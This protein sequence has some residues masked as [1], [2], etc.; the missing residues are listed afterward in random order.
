MY[1]ARHLSKGLRGNDYIK[2]VIT[3]VCKADND[4]VRILP[5]RHGHKRADHRR[6]VISIVGSIALLGSSVCF[7]L[8]TA[9]KK[10]VL[11]RLQ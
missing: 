2:I 4:I 3:K 8:M 1:C 7:R 5:N 11:K 9:T 6:P 10:N